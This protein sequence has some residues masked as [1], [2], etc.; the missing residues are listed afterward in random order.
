[1]RTIGLVFVIAVVGAGCGGSG[2]AGTPSIS[3]PSTSPTLIVTPPPTARTLRTTV[4]V[5]LD[6]QA[7]LTQ[8]VDVGGFH[9]PFK[10]RI[11][12]DWTPVLRDAT[13]F[14]TY[15]GNEAFEITFD[16]TYTVK[17]SVDQAIA[18]LTA[19][20]G[21]KA[22]PIS[23]VVIGGRAGKGFVGDADAA[24]MFRDSGFHTNGAARLEVIAIPMKDGTTITVFLT[25]VDREHGLD[26]LSPL[27]RRI[28][29]TVKWQ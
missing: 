18:R 11:P 22:G 28:F 1:M 29:E 7:P 12:A 10:L 15:Q 8:S 25:T 14:Q 13:A 21:L 24:V 2:T 4:P 9:P 23:A 16:H 19:T 27:A 26:T 3:A 6:P 20:R 17:E 5:R